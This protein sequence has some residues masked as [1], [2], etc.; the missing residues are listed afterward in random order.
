MRSRNWAGVTAASVTTM[1]VSMG[2]VAPAAQAADSLTPK[3]DPAVAG[4]PQAPGAATVSADLRI[5]TDATGRPHAAVRVYKSLLPEEFADATSQFGTC[6]RKVIEANADGS[7]KPAPA[8]P[9]ESVLGSGVLESVIPDLALSTTTDKLIIYNNGGGAITMWFH[10]SQPTGF[11]GTANGTLS[12]SAA[13]FG[14]TVTWDFTGAA[15]G[16]A[17]YS[18]Y[19]K[20]LLTSFVPRGTTSTAP[21]AATPPSSPPKLS[22]AQRKKRLATCERRARKRWSRAPKRRAR[23]IRACRRKYRKPAATTRQAR[24]RAESGTTKVSPFQST[25]CAGGMWR[26]QAQLEFKGEQPANLDGSVAC[27]AAG[28]GG[29]APPSGPAPTTP[30]CGLPICPPQAPTARSG[31]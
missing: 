15:D 8:C 10:V 28:A 22:E 3:V 6:D 31:S 23:S 4:T 5:A 24:P 21:P 27:S 19:V 17:G 20:R 13:P 14:P 11:T 18:V 26:F 25:G 9:V 1:L 7:D 30:A 2:A 29:T 12:R 16:K